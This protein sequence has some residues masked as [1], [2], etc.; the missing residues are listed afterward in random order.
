MD[1]FESCSTES[2]LFQSKNNNLVQVEPY[3]QHT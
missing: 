2:E 1:I 3:E